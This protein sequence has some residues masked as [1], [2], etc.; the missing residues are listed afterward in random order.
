MRLYLVRHAV[1]YEHGDPNFANDDDR[2]LTPKG[3]KQFAKAAEG[4]FELIDPP[5]AILTSP[6]PRAQMFTHKQ[7]VD[8]KVDLYARHGS[9]TWQRLGEYPI[10]RKLLTE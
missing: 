8:V 2:P 4:L 3:R 6:L 7:W 9:R 1:A 5:A 10:E